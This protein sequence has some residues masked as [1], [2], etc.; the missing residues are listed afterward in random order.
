MNN[1]RAWEQEYQNPQFLTLGTEPLAD[2]RDFIKW[3]RRKQKVD[4]TEFTVLDL[5]C[6]NGKN[7]NYI[8]DL[9]AKQGIGYDI[10]PTAINHARELAGTLPVTYEVRSI[11]DTFPLEDASIDLVMDVTAS[12]SL[13]EGERAKFLK[14]ISRVLKPGS[15]CFTRALCKDGDENAKNL[16]KDFP[17]SEHDTYV[18]AETGITERVF[19][20]QDFIDTY[21]PYFEIV[22]LDKKTG[23]QRWGN[24]KYK[25]NYW[26]AYLKIKKK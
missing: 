2:V 18:L 23:Y 13:N 24:Q 5:G 20:K 17:G 21:S 26:L 6:G 3:L 4:T 8:V 9:F 25:R 7:L 10:S 22:E 11:S 19:S 1:D 14:E 16:I 12:N 15:Y